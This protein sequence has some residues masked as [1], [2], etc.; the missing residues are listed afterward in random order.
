MNTIRERQKE[1]HERTQAHE[2]RAKECPSSIV[3]A[4]E[5]IA[6]NQVA[7]MNS[8]YTMFNILERKR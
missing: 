6:K 7:I 8:L 5:D 3:A 4:M 1:L 2:K